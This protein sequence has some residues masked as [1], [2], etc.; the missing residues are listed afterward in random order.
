MKKAYK[1]L[2]FG[3]LIMCLSLGTFTMTTNAASQLTT[4]VI[5]LSN[6]EETGKVQISW[7]P[8]KKA[9]S[10]KV[11]RSTDGKKWKCISTT[12]NCRRNIHSSC[13]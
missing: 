1:R 6:N 2:V 4:P 5:T 11:Y 7:E 10:Y 9:V 3:L 8:V 12:K 13:G